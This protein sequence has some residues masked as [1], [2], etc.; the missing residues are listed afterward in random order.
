MVQSRRAAS[1]VRKHHP[2]SSHRLSIVIHTSMMVRSSQTQSRTSRTIL[3]CQ[4]SGPRWSQD[5][6]QCD[7]PGVQLFL[8]CLL[9]MEE[10][11]TFDTAVLARKLF[12]VHALKAVLSR[13]MKMQPIEL[14]GT[15]NCKSSIGPSKCTCPIEDLQSEMT[16]CMEC[17][18]VV[19]RVL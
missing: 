12:P 1:S 17:Y 4:S 18:G 16:D 7:S 9:T 15:F 5:H 10:M 8:V 13:I 2:D 11:C 3:G 19:S 6:S 14:A